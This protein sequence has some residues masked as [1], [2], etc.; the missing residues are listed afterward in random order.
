[1]DIKILETLSIN[2]LL[3][4]IKAAKSLLEKKDS[5]I[6]EYINTLNL[7]N[8]YSR[9]E[10]YNNYLDWTNT[11]N[12]NSVSNESFNIYINSFSNKIKLSK[13]IKTKPSKKRNSG[14]IVSKIET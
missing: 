6:K 11:N 5:P 8:E 4:V 1:M 13:R 3:E 14:D 10:L 9:K 2:E 7:E 12:K